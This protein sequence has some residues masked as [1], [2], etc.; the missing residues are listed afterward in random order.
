MEE[1]NYIRQYLNGK[2]TNML[3]ITNSE[4]LINIFFTKNGQSIIEFIRN[5][6][7]IY[8]QTLEK[9]EKLNK[10]IDKLIPNS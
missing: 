8:Y 10:I 4:N 1:E 5:L 6:S 3:N 9:M 2:F 7:I